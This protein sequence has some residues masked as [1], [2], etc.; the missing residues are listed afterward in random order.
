MHNTQLISHASGSAV[1]RRESTGSEYYRSQNPDL[2][3][4]SKWPERKRDN[5]S[6]IIHNK[7]SKSNESDAKDGK[8]AKDGKEAKDLKSRRYFV[9]SFLSIVY[10][11]N[12]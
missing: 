1:G 5:T 6:D 8:V 10:I 7:R 9:V 11:Q 3:T 12:N 2:R 4:A